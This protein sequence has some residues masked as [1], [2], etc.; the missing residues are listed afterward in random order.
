MLVLFQYALDLWWQLCFHFRSTAPRV[1]LNI[2]K[3][4]KSEIGPKE[5]LS[6][7]VFVCECWLEFYGLCLTEI[8]VGGRVLYI[9][10]VCVCVHVYEMFLYVCACHCA[11]IFAYV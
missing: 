5:C 10:C 4:I 1:V 9:L 8:C 11:C 7:C 2:N 3:V 6:R